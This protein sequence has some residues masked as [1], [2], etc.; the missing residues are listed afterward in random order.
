MIK[1]ERYPHINSLLAYYVEAL[2]NDDMR[3]LLTDGVQTESEAFIFARFVWAMV[4]RMCDDRKKGRIVLGR[5]DN[6]DLLPDLHYEA[7]QYLQHVGYE[8][9]WDRVTDEV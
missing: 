3:R 7:S 2:E 9:V 5:L 1:F 6:G 8:S 4:D